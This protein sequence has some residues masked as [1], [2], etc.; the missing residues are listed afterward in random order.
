MDTWP[1]L[2]LHRGTC[3]NHATWRIDADRGPADR[4]HGIACDEH[5]D[6]VMRQCGPGAVATPIADPNPLGGT[7][8]E[9]SLFDAGEAP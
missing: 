3:T 6:A 7:P 1:A 9:P 8:R 5:R 4:R 2:C